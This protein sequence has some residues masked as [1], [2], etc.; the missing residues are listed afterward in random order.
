MSFADLVLDTALEFTR[1]YKK[2]AVDWAKIEAAACYVK[3]VDL[4]RRQCLFLAMQVFALV[5]FAL[6]VILFP[7][8]VIV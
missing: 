2:K 7:L 8:V 6:S 3:G 1:A 4:V 5:L